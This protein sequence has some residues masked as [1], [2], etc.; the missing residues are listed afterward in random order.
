MKLATAISL[1]AN[2]GYGSSLLDL[3]GDPNETLEAKDRVRRR[4]VKTNP[5]IDEMEACPSAF[6]GNT[7]QEQLNDMME[8]RSFS[9]EESGKGW[10]T[11]S[12]GDGTGKDAWRNGR[13][14]KVFFKGNTI[15]KV[16]CHSDES[17]VRI[18]QGWDAA[19]GFAGAYGD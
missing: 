16:I 15:G 17:P 12:R 11:Y 1:F 5:D 6:E 14:I 7:I 13:W 9:K 4:L 19:Y 3:P 2:A 18:K 10:V 8:Q